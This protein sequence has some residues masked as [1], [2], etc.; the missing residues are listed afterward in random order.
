MLSRPLLVKAQWKLLNVLLRGV[1]FAPNYVVKQEIQIVGDPD[2]I[3]SSFGMISW[4]KVIKMSFDPS[5]LGNFLE[6]TVNKERHVAVEG[7]L[8]ELSSCF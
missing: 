8:Q 1:S 6:A 2:G 4:G 5:H 7:S 3:R